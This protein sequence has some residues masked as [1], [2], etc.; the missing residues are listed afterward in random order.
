MMDHCE[1]TRDL[2]LRL[3]PILTVV[4]AIPSAL[5]KCSQPTNLMGLLD[6]SLR[7]CLFGLLAVFHENKRGKRNK[8]TSYALGFYKAHR[9]PTYEKKH[10]EEVLLELLLFQTE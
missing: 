1:Y 2:H 6:D 8:R 9:F 10:L 7:V 5:N 3:I 4:I